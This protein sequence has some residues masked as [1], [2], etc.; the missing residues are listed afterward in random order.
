V[1]HSVCEAP[2]ISNCWRRLTEVGIGLAVAAL[3]SIAPA[4]AESAVCADPRARIQQYG[5]D[6]LALVQTN[7]RSSAVF[8]SCVAVGAHAYHGPGDAASSTA[9]FAG[10]AALGCIA[11]DSYSNCVSVNLQ[12]FAIALKTAAVHDILTESG[13]DQ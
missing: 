12:L 6:A 9:A 2:A 4:R 7:P 3:L 13:C 1:A 11:A 5:L 8:T 10:C